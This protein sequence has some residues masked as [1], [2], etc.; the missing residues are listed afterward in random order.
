MDEGL[1]PG[2]IEEPG[3]QLDLFCRPDEK[4]GCRDLVGLVAEDALTIQGSTSFGLLAA[5]KKKFLPFGRG[6]FI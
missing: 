3:A 1:N 4:K 5:Q 2:E 6:E